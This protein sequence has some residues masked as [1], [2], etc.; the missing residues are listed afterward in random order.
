MMM[1]ENSTSDAAV[2][3][4]DAAIE[5]LLR[6]KASGARYVTAQFTRYGRSPVEGLYA[7]SWHDQRFEG[8]FVLSFDHADASEL[9]EMRVQAD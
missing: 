9:A 4:I 3:S 6:A 5:L 1:A 8:G 7:G 2:L